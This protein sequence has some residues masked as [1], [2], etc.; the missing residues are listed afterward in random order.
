MSTS[1]RSAMSCGVAIGPHV[2]ADDD[3]VRRRGE[4][5]VRLVDG[6][7]ARA[8]DADLDLLVRQ[9]GQRVGEHFGRALHVG[10]DDE[11]QLLHAAFGDLLL[12]R[13]E[14]E[15]A[16]LGAERA[17]LGLRLPER[18]DLP[19]LRRVGHRLERIAG[20]RQAGQA[21]HFDR[22]RR[23]GRLRRTAAVVD[24]RADPA[25]HRAGDEVV[26][27]AERAVLHEHRRHRAAAA[28]ELGFEHRAR[29]AAL[30]VR[31][32]ARGCRST[33]GSSRAADRGSAAS[34]PTP[35]P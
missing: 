34:S 15:P 17:L 26:A 29:R 2:E 16:A 33:A 32:A 27:D 28:I 5:H 10:L 23:A 14:R 31:L 7:D 30:R 35:A 4:Q 1:S 18:R 24:Q 3:R 13:F 8:D 11:R 20:L 12:E 6:A 9:L 25:D 21:E 22:R 19:R